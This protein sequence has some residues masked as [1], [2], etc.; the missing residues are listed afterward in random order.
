MPEENPAAPVEPAQEPSGEGTI[1]GQVG[2]K[3]PERVPS[4]WQDDPAYRESQRL[5][6]KQADDARAATAAAQ[7]QLAAA[8]AEN[9]SL[10]QAS[11][12]QNQFIQTYDPDAAKALQDKAHLNRVEAELAQS[13]QQNAQQNADAQAR[14]NF[15]EYHTTRAQE[16]G[17]N[18]Y[19]PMYQAALNQ[20]M[21]Q[22]DPGIIE[23]ARLEMAISA[24]SAADAAPPAP[25]PVPPA[26]AA[27]PA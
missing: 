5:L 21:V 23:G 13:R 19:D 16:Q 27:A 7:Q 1:E 26:G 6:N 2:E 22:G 8:Q 12:E 14:N 18:P 4:N 24:R 11:T 17:L 20:A 10:R 3:T 9:Q 15:I 25:E